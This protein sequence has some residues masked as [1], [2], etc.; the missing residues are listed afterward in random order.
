MS[1]NIN[2]AKATKLFVVVFVVVAVIGIV[3]VAVANVAA[4]CVAV[5][6][7]VVANLP[8]T[9]AKAVFCRFQSLAKKTL[10]FCCKFESKWK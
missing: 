6:A 8:T 3:I 7:A 2:T 10:N 5:A 9:L 1:R 4:A